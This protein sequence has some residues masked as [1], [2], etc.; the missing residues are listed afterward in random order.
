M[1]EETE[2]Q[3]CDSV[4]IKQLCNEAE[5][6]FETDFLTLKLLLFLLQIKEAKRSIKGV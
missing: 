4:S 1:E 3:T 5:S 2:F 6:S